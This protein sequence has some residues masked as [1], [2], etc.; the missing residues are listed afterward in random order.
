MAASS[1]S[2]IGVE[3]VCKSA[4][5]IVIFCIVSVK[6]TTVAKSIDIALGGTSLISI[7]TY[8]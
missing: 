3:P 2:V 5:F 6:V 8:G 4:S 1:A 7:P